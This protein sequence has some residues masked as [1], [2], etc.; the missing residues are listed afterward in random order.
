MSRKAELSAHS[1]QSGFTSGHAALTASMIKNTQREARS[2]GEAAGCGVYQEM[3]MEEAVSWDLI[4]LA[5]K[6]VQ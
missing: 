4:S 1:V 5:Q 2:V 6:L 3:K